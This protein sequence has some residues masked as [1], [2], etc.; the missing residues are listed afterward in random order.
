MRN[1]RH[2]HPEH[3]QAGAYEGVPMKADTILKKLDRIENL[4]TL[5]SIVMEVNKMLQDHN[6]DIRQLS[7][8]IER[9]QSFVSKI[10][11]I[12][13]SAFFGLRSKVGNIS[14][15]ITLL[16]FSTIRNA[17][18]SVSV[19]NAFSDDGNF[20]GF[21]ITNFWKHSIAVAVTSRYLAAKTRL[22]S[23]DESFIGGLLHDIGKVILFQYFNDLFLEV[24]HLFKNSGQPFYLAEQEA[25]Q[26][27][28]AQIGAYLAEKWQLPKEL[29]NAIRYHH[30]INETLNDQNLLMI[31]HTSDLISNDLL[32]NPP[33]EMDFSKVSPNALNAL[34]APLS[35]VSS[36]FPEVLQEIESAYQ[37][38]IN[39]DKS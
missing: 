29:V 24:W 15:A 4:P 17:V 22:H 39:E 16:G 28:H 8:L 19:I 6:T 31:V 34:E 32:T 18:L 20:T 23:P 27:D 33:R 10:L 25:L 11:R 13:N 37:I 26:I 9:D 38:L 12:V 30:E 21:D 14:H 3:D 36:W 5:P 2:S 7:E 1:H 35:M